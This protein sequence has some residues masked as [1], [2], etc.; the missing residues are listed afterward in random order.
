MARVSL[1]AC[2]VLLL[3]FA[4][5]LAWQSPSSDGPLSTDRR[6]RPP[7]VEVTPASIRIDAALVLVP[8]NVTT[9]AGVPVTNLG[10]DDFRLFEDNVEQPITVFRQ[11]DAPV[12]IGLLFDTSGSMHGKMRKA[13]EAAAAFFQTANPQDEFFLVSFGDRPKLAMAFTS[14]SDQVFRRISG[15]RPF[16]RTSLLDAI[17]LALRQ[18]KTARNSRK[19]LIVVS[20][21]GDNFSRRSAGQIRSALLESDVRLYAMGIFD[22]QEHYRTQ[23]ERNG[24]VLL[25]D[26]AAHTGGKNY[27][28]DN[29][30]E[31]PAISVRIS[32]LLRTE[33]LLGY[34]PASAARDG[35]YHRLKVTLAV[36]EGARQFHTTYREGYY[37]PAQ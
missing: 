18:M 36:P 15:F 25:D 4:E 2:V 27:P 26:L 1:A 14:D 17:D 28:V 5:A 31:L 21:G 22:A 29:L 37:A 6:A 33:Y 24:P 34:S 13:C 12:S 10:Q 8:T 23:E 30:D 32:R 20:D 16:G 9:P 19:A 7:G 3:P 35:K 11:D